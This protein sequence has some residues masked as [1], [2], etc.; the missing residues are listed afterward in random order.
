MGSLF[1]LAARSIRSMVSSLSVCKH[2][3][4]CLSALCLGSRVETGG[5]TKHRAIVRSKPICT[6]RISLSSSGF[7]LSASCLALLGRWALVLCTLVF[8]WELQEDRSA[9]LLLAAVTP[10]KMTCWPALA[11]R[12]LKPCICFCTALLP[13]ATCRRQQRWIRNL[14]PV[15]P[16]AARPALCPASCEESLAFS[17][18]SDFMSTC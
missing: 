7:C 6:N 12:S 3:Q 8:R 1:S 4:G 5:R 10:W 15:C 18:A 14:R 17:I 9:A 11:W 13:A 2:L 16:A